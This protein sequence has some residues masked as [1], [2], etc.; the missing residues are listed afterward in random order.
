MTLSNRFGY[1]EILCA[2]LQSYHGAAW[3]LVFS[4]W[5]AERT[6]LLGMMA[7]SILWGRVCVWRSMS[8][9]A[10]MVKQSLRGSSAPIHSYQYPGQRATRGE[11]LREASAAVRVLELFHC[12]VSSLVIRPRPP[13][14]TP[15]WISFSPELRYPETVSLQSPRYRAG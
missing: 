11:R 15:S 3:S 2:S 14:M 4:L 13:G 8:R 10:S 1:F 7:C 6:G 5:C 12:R 9:P